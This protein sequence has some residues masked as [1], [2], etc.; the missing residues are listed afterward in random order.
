MSDDKPITLGAIH[1]YGWNWFSYHAQQR[2]TV[3]RFYFL[4]VGVLTVGY[5]QSLNG[6]LPALGFGFAVLGMV[7]SFLFWRLDQR[8]RELVRIGEDLL[9]ETEKE[10]TKINPISVRIVHE[11]NSKTSKHATT[12]FP[13]W[14][15]SYGQVFSLIF[16]IVF[17]AFGIAAFWAIIEADWLPS[18]GRCI[19]V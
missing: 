1:D 18:F 8:T 19:K 6:K 11:A 4:L 12:W 5:Y 15:Y 17:L 3:F 9:L 14:V 13:S 2:M 7:F 10:F 16:S